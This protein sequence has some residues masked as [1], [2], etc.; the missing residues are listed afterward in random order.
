[1]A[2]EE[3]ETAREQRKGAS[4]AEAAVSRHV[5][6]EVEHNGSTRRHSSL[7]RLWDL[8][9]RLPHSKQVWMLVACLCLLMASIF[10]WDGHADAAFVA[11]TLGVVAW[12]VDLR[13]R[14]IRRS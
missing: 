3:T 1:L 6:A 8:T 13:N 14:L 4:E 12:F 10:W 11:A 7:T 5:N 2:H 9:L